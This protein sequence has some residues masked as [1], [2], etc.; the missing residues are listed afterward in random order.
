MDFQK[1]AEAQAECSWVKELRSKVNRDHLEVKLP[2]TDLTLLCDIGQAIRRPIVPPAMRRQVFDEVHGFSHFNPRHTTSEA[3]KHF[4]WPHIHKTV[5]EWAE[6]CHKCQQ[7]KTGRLTVSPLQEFKVPKTVVTHIHID[8]VGP[9]PSSDGFT[10][11]LTISD[12]HSSFVVAFPLVTT[13]TRAVIR[14]MQTAW[15]PY[16]GCPKKITA[17][18]GSNFLCQYQYF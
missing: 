2:D 8:V 1:L 13:T 15:Y 5:K 6:T 4:W 16:F 18:R 14:A 9:L 12:R 3:T 7:A 10:G 17:D 11:W